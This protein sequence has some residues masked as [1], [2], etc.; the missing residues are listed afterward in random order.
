MG[1]DRVVQF[2]EGG[3]PSWQEVAD[4]LAKREFPIQVRMIDGELA[5]PDENPPHAWRELRVGTPHGM[6]S[7]RRDANRVVCI[8]WGNADSALRQAWNAVAW[9]FAQAGGGRVESDAGPQTAADFLD[10]AEMPEGVR[11]GTT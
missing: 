4:L 11:R 10:G 5:L 2:T 1:I 7:I 6:I 9:G 8:T 3:F